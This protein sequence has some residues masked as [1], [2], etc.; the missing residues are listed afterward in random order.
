METFSY[1]KVA[2]NQRRPGVAIVSISRLRNLC[3]SLAPRYSDRAQLFPVREGYDDAIQLLEPL[4]EVGAIDVVLA[5][6]SNGAY[7]RDRLAV[8]VVMVKVNGFDVIRAISEAAERRPHKRIGLV[9]HESV[10]AELGLLRPWLN[11]EILQRAYRSVD[12]VQHQVEALVDEGCATIIGPGMACDFAEQASVGSV[13]LYSLGAVEEAFERSLELARVSREKESKRARINTIVA[14]LRDGVAAFDEGGRLEAVNPAMRA[15]LGLESQGDV[16]SQLTARIGT[17]LRESIANDQAIVERIEHL[18][19]RTLSFDCMPISEHGM[20]TG[21]VVSV[22]DALVAQRIDRTLRTTQRPK[23]L[24]AQHQLGDLI[25]S[26]PEMQKTRRQA[27]TSASHDA[28]VLLTGESGTG[29]ELVAQGIHRASKRSGNPFLAFNC[30]ALPEGLIESELFGHEEGAFTGARR[31]GKQGLFEMAHTGTILLDEIGEMPAAL[32]SRLLRVLQ[33]RQV[34]KLGAGRAIPVD[35]R[36]IAATHR[37]LRALV[38]QG[39]FRADLFFRLNVLHIAIPS[40]RERRSDLP[41][42]ADHLLQGILAQYELPATHS[43]GVLKLL[44]PLFADYQ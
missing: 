13:F 27:M 41:E 30:A 43:A 8:P 38:A 21:T 6:G 10:S 23:H 36:V 19:G 24:L 44:A 9:L 32:Q 3:E 25:G 4:I 42:I 14:H 1:Q 37:D 29:K 39:L 26:S 34:M 12:E 40:L 11:F 18:D 20:R 16:S 17:L 22:Q 2:V 33:E 7:L 15:L 31:G 5:A 28:T 35:V